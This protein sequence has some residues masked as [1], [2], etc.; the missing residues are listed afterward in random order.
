MMTMVDGRCCADSTNIT[1][2]S[3]QEG[4]T[5]TTTTS[6]HTT[7]THRREPQAN[8]PRPHPHSL[9]GSGHIQKA[10]IISVAGDSKWAGSPDFDLSADEMKAIAE[11]YSSENAQASAYGSGLRLAGEPYTVIRIE[12]IT[13]LLRCK[14]E[15]KEKIGACIGKAK[16]CI[17]VGYYD[18]N[19]AQPGNAN[20]AV[21]ALVEYLA[22]AGY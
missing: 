11:V 20:Q 17:V 8:A 13:I 9:V 19:I 2:F 3:A 14:V 21:Q 1:V 15:G 7:K 22:K 4:S 18:G 5:A 16:Q 10:A 6:Y 12:D